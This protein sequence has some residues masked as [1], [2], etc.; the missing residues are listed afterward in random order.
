[1]ATNQTPRLRWPVLLRSRTHSAFDRAELGRQRLP[2]EICPRHRHNRGRYLVHNSLHNLRHL[3]QGDPLLPMHL[4]KSRGFAAIISAASVGSCVYYS[5]IILWPS[6]IASLLG[7]SPIHQ[8]LLASMVGTGTQLGQFMAGPMLHWISYQRG[9]LFFT[10]C[11]LTAMAGAMIAV[12][13]GSVSLDCGLMLTA[14]WCIGVIECIAVVLTPLSCPPEDLGAALGALGSV[15]ST[16]AM[17]A[18]AIYVA[19]L[20]SKLASIT[21][22]LVSQAALKNVLPASSIPTLLM[23]T[24]TGNFTNVPGITPGITLAVEAAMAEASARSFSMSGTRSL[25]S[26][27]SQSSLRR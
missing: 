16:A 18:T 24:A 12:G 2:L 21:P 4:F 20:N 25:R 6:Q 9:L 5:M 14:C 13:P 26:A 19:I 8:A 22:A 23:D 11:L 17:C 27:V 1:M 10:C 3:P 7:G 15:R